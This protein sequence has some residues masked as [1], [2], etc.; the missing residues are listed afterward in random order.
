MLIKFSVDHSEEPEMIEFLKYFEPYFKNPH[1]W[2]YCYR[3]HTGINTNMRLERLHR[4]IKYEYLNGKR[5][6]R[7]DKSITVIMRLVRDKLFQKL[8]SGHKGK[9]CSTISNIR[10]RHKTSNNIKID[11]IYETENHFV[12]PSERSAEL[13]YVHREMDTCKCSL[14]CDDCNICIHEFY[15]TCIDS[16]IKFNMCKDIHAVASMI[17]KTKT[18]VE[19]SMNLEGKKDKKFFIFLH[20]YKLQ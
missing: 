12:V 18:I 19:S 8:I 6:K 7:L 14:R 4:T 11:L 13:Y 2:A 16:A 15:C 5:V 17:Q 1:L 9:L 20:L 10:L 3:K